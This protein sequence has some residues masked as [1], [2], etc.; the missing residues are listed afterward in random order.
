[1]PNVTIFTSTGT[2]AGIDAAAGTGAAELAGSTA[3]ALTAGGGA[4][5]AVVAEVEDVGASTVATGGA[6]TIAATVALVDACRVCAGCGLVV[7]QATSAKVVAICGMARTSMLRTISHPR[8]A[9]EFAAF[10]AFGVARSGA[11]MRQFVQ[12]RSDF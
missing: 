8:A 3:L 11:Q 1:M 2:V 5:V 12:A 9:A 7:P 4:A 10:S 6:M